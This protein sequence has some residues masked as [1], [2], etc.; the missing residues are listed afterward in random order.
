MEYRL[1]GKLEVLR[2]GEEIDVGT[3]RQ[4]SLLAYLLINA[5]RIV[6]TDQII[7]SLWGDDSGPDRLNALW[8][9]ISGLRSLLEP[10]REKRSEGTILLTRSPGYLLQVEPGAIDVV[11]FE[12]LVAEGR[13]LIDTDPAAASLVLTEALA[14]WRGH[15]LEEFAYEAFATAEIA[16]L[17]ELRFEAVEHRID[18]DLRRGMSVE[19]LSELESLVHQHPLR[20]RVAGLSMLA[21]YRSGRQAEALRSYQRLKSALGEELGI[22]PSD[23]IRKLEGRIAAGDPA[24][25]PKARLAES[26]FG[27]RSGLAVRGYELR[28]KIDESGL[29]VVYHGYQPATGRRVAIKVIRPELADDPVFIRRFEA[30]AQLVAQLEHPNIVPIYDYWR[31]PGAA[32]LVMRMV[33][34]TNLTDAVIERGQHSEQVVLLLRQI[35]GALRS[36]HSLGL[37]HGDLRPENVLMDKSGNAYLAGFAVAESDEQIARQRDVEGFA[38]I[39]SIV[40]T[41]P[42]GSD[43]QAPTEAVAAVLD[44]GA[45]YDTVESLAKDLIATLAGEGVTEEH[46]TAGME[47][48]PN[49]YVGLRAF[50]R[51]DAER[52]FGRQ[53][54]VDRL[55]GRLGTPGSVGRFVAVVGPSGSGKSSLVRAGLLPALAAGAVPMSNDWFVIDMVPAPHP[56]EALEDALDRVSAKPDPALLERLAATTSGIRE[57]SRDLV[58]AGTQLLLFI[59]QFEEL[60]TQVDADTADRFIDGLVDAV[61]SRHTQLRLVI[62][63]RADFYDRP[64]ERRGLGELLR[65]GTEP[66]TPMT[67]DELESAITGPARLAGV[68]VEPSLVARLI[69]DTENRPGALP[70]LQYTLTELY[71][72]RSSASISLAD[73][74]AMGGLSGAL[75]Q[76]ADG[77]YSGLGSS[78]REATRQVFLRLV[79][80]GEDAEDTRRRVP[81]NE[82]RQLP[83]SGRDLDDVLD[84]FGRHRLLSFDRDP[85]SREPTVEITHEAL[86]GQWSRLGL[87]IRQAR[88]DIR[89]QRRLAMAMGEWQTADRSDAYLLQG[90]RL[91]QLAGWAAI[92][93]VPLSEPE[94]AFLDASLSLRAMEEKEAE[95]REV[96]AAAAEQSARQRL[97]WLAIAVT[98]VAMLSAISAF[99]L[100]QRRSARVAEA[101]I[102][103]SAFALQLAGEANLL[104]GSDPELSLLLAIEAMRATVDGGAITPEALDAMHWAIQENVI[105]YPADDNTSVAVRSGPRG[106]RGVF[107]LPPDELAALASGATDRSFST[108]ECRLFFGGRPCPDPHQP[109]P[110]GLSIARG[111]ESYG[112]TEN[113]P[114]AL[115]GATVEIIGSWSPD[116]AWIELGPFE[117][118]TG[119]NIAYDFSNAEAEFLRRAGD[120]LPLPD[121]AYSPQASFVV[122]RGRE[123]RLIDV[124]AYLD[125]ADLR[126]QFGSYQIAMM[127]V[128]P[129][130]GWPSS[131]GALYGV[132]IDV[133]LKGLVY[134]RRAAFEEAGY[135]VPATWDEL[136][137]LS[138]RMVID[139]RVPWC[140]GFEAA[141]ADGWPGTDWIE[142]LVLREAG[143]ELYDDWTFRRIA[144]D[145]PAIRAAANRFDELVSAPGA[146]LMGL[147]N[148]TKLNVITQVIPGLMAEEPSCWMYHQGDF[149]MAFMLPTAE[150]GVDV[151]FFML[152]PIDPSRPVPSTGG[153]NL[154]VV[155]GDRPEVR[156]LLRH[157][158]SPEWGQVWAGQPDSQFLSPN[159]L[160]DISRYGRN[161]DPSEREA[162]KAIGAAVR[163]A[164]ASG[165]FRYDASD[166]MPSVIGGFDGEGPGAFWK[167]MVDYANGVR[168]MDQ[169]LEDIEAAWVALESGG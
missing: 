148:V 159:T 87:W 104:L 111:E 91:D 150:F 24:L 147:E 27:P 74:R 45:D 160:F 76:R 161:A 15:A 52:F 41:G 131:A 39:A 20:E 121:V 135:E 154:A 36:V 130:G 144:F 80:V 42:S 57:V 49:P 23:E 79:N 157:I 123:G 84:C 117:E 106:V 146:V 118:A 35:S 31:E 169:V 129:D 75:L 26:V 46:P 116:L 72:G 51:A 16:R 145:D 128:A 18:A 43:R 48:A 140:L 62:T 53:R 119:I 71:A 137:A 21:L 90:G 136:V 151:D 5:N 132:P 12:R 126:R 167:G 93:T 1:L 73:Y 3:F 44:R 47:P 103:Q 19:L 85:V 149:A 58:P 162:R 168:T 163:D 88:H 100:I 156:A 89:N 133:D 25:Q 122:E 7:D 95:E 77:L 40:L 54:L 6:S 115:N 68:T 141:A 22:E 81:L 37:S 165:T 143:P 102:A 96:Q 34:T 138:Q 97:R 114:G 61:T 4:R 152:P 64:L 55:V 70:L 14:L 9:Y 65:D 99:A 78:A 166:L 155:T 8:V 2:N 69:R 107:V 30:E 94:R 66:T 38:R 50:D 59:D 127:T 17:E 92:T 13:A 108:S 60:F 83:I 33:G 105:T 134:Y 120:G 63:M 158:A 109:L 56:F 11:R 86:L 10:S 164:L 153:A 28:D 98:V 67:S 29:G 32:Y 82:L 139:G 124:S 113:L 110:G 112:V 125:V 101:A 142:S